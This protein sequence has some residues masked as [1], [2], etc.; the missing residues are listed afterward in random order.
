MRI[1]RLFSNTG[2]DI[3]DLALSEDLCYEFVDFDSRNSEF[4]VENLFIAD[5]IVPDQ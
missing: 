4:V 1:H 2:T 3:R 5:I